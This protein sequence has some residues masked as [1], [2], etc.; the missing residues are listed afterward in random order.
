MANLATTQA[1]IMKLPAELTTAAEQSIFNAGQLKR[2]FQRTPT[3]FIKTRE[4][5]G[6]QFSYVPGGY[7]K[8]ELDILFGFNWDFE[9]Q[10][11]ERVDDDI[12]VIGKLTGRTN[13]GTIVKTQAGGAKVKYH[14]KFEN[15][16]KVSDKTR[17][18]NYGNDV[19]A[20]ITDALK[21]CAAD[22]GVARDIY[23]ANEFMEA[24]IID[25]EIK[26]EE[27][28]EEDKA[29]MAKLMAPVTEEEIREIQS[30]LMAMDFMDSSRI[31]KAATG[32]IRIDEKTMDEA[33]WRRLRDALKELAQ[34]S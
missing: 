31:I 5:A 28:A 29:E 22:M 26:A 15:G 12:F 25:T 20:A 8:R 23:Y 2:L 32:K 1:K 27:A 7:V 14:T 34:K 30:Q 4:V 9:V 18:L 21:K 33:K 16:K 13:N 17:M 6:H 3:E 11:V 10:M 19:K 24:E